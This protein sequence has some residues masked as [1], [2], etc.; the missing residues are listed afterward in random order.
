LRNRILFWSLAVVILGC[1]EPASATAQRKEIVQLQTTVDLLQQQVRELQRSVDERTAVLRTLIEQ[2]VDAVSRM[3]TTVAD[4][5]RTVKESQAN[6]GTRVDSLSS[7]LQAVRDTVD[8]MGRRVAQ[9]SEQLAETRNVLQSVDARLAPPLPPADSPAAGAAT[10]PP[11]FP[12]PDTLYAAAKRDL[13]GGKLDLARQQFADYL[14]YY[15][16][17]LLAGNAQFYIGE[18]YYQEKEYARAVEEYDHVLAK[19]PQSFKAAAALLKKGFALIR[20]NEHEAGV[21]ALR[22]V[23]RDHP[24]SDEAKLAR[25]ELRRLGVSATGTS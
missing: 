14:K 15:G 4:L 8:E 7:Q 24:N 5:E 2:A 1:L 13:D 10:P 20:L 9:L 11:N 18:T 25:A 22:T 6:T 23:V 17:T 12:S 21:R 3:G 19:Y 16:N